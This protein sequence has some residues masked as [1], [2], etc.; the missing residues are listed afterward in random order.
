MQPKR[1]DI[2]EII[3]PGRV[4]ETTYIGTCGR[5]GARIS[6]TRFWTPCPTRGCDASISADHRE[7]REDGKLVAIY[8]TRT[9]KKLPLPG[10]GYGKSEVEESLT[11]RWLSLSF[12][13]ARRNREE[14]DKYGK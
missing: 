10:E 2:V 7:E 5:C 12:W 1:G 6:S 11:P 9:G 3:K 8:E 13:R 14:A 4:I